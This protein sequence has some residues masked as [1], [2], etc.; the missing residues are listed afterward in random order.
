MLQAPDFFDKQILI[1]PIREGGEGEVGLRVRNS[2]LVFTRGGKVMNQVPLHRLFAVFVVGDLTIT[3]QLLA[4]VKEFGASFFLV[5]QNFKPRVALVACAE[6]HFVLRARQYTLSDEKA[7]H[8]SQHIV[9][10][11]IQNQL[12]VLGSPARSARVRD[13]L[14]EINRA[15]SLSDLLGYEGYAS[16]RYF[17]EMFAST[18]WR[19]RAPRTREDIPNLLLDIGYHMLF[20]FLDALLSLH[21]F[22]VYR[23]VYHQMFFARKSLV[24]DIQEPFRPLIDHA[25]RRA[26]NLGMVDEE[27]F[28]FNRQAG[29][30]MLPWKSAPRYYRIFS[31][32]IMKH[33]MDM[34]AYVRGFYRHIMQPERYPM[35]DFII[36]RSLVTKKKTLVPE[37]Q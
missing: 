28:S 1:L 32:V 2:N 15:Q 17:A 11:K 37:R 22:D 33:K 13:M 16:R 23:G 29:E 36:P 26:Y 35:P 8:I 6:G 9:C 31:E 14:D 4:K 30:F 20:N 3:T 10:N 19:R 7:L 12:R 34:F 5:G 24:A 27:D 25:L 21:G 18:G